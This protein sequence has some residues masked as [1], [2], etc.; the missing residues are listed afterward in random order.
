MRKVSNRYARLLVV[1]VLGALLVSAGLSFYGNLTGSSSSKPGATAKDVKSSAST[2]TS[3]KK[4]QP[5]GGD[6][7]KVLK[8]DLNG[9][10]TVF[11]TDFTNAAQL[12]T[13][14]KYVKQTNGQLREA[15]PGELRDAVNTSTRVSDLLADS[16]VKGVKPSLDALK[17]IRS[18]EFQTAAK[19]VA[20]YAKDQCGISPS[21][22]S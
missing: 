3:S 13:Y 1:A 7:C 5:G 11:P 8:D 20:A 15:A 2:G 21:F 6:F 12:K 16:Y 22:G 4:V 9:L 14:G 17:Q 10:K 19:K 18:A